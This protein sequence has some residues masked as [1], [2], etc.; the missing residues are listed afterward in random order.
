MFREAAV[1]AHST[2]AYIRVIWQLSHYFAAPHRYEHVAQ[3]LYR[4]CIAAARRTKQDPVAVLQT[5]L[6]RGW[7]VSEVSALGRAAKTTRTLE[8]RCPDC[9]AEVR[10]TMQGEA[11]FP[12]IPCPVCCAIAWADGGDGREA[13]RLGTLGGEA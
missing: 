7:H 11:T 10:V 1:G 4:A 3:A 8:T 5:A 13:A 12:P 2:V 6:D 9:D